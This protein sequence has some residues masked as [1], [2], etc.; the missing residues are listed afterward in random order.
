[1]F[2]FLVE[3]EDLVEPMQQEMQVVVALMAILA[4]AQALLDQMA[5][6]ELHQQQVQLARKQV[7]VV[8]QALELLVLI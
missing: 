4:V 1:M 8:Q 5:L 6:M 7:E 3:M 2:S